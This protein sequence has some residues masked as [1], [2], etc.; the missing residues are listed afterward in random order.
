[1]K[2]L[3]VANR[4][5]VA[6]RIIRT[7]HALGIETVAVY[8]EAD[9]GALHVREATQACAI[10]GLTSADSYLRI[11]KLVSA[12]RS[13]GADAVHPG[14][15]FLSENAEFAQAVE[16]AGITWV[17][18]GADAIRTL[19]SKTRA[20]QLAHA[21]GVPCLPGYEGPDQSDQAFE[22]AGRDLGFPLM[23]KAAAGG[24]GRGMRLVTEAARLL[25]AVQSA[26]SEALSAFGSGELLLECALLR[27][28]H[29]EIQVFADL[30]GN[31][32]H[33]GERDCSVQRRHQ[34]IIEETPSPA[35][36]PELREAMGQCAIELARAAGYV[37]AGTVEFLLDADGAFYLMEMNTRLQVEHP[38]TEMVTGL[39]LVEWQLRIACGERL[40]CRQ[41]ELRF[42]GHAIEVRLCAEDEHFVPHSGRIS[43]FLPPPLGEGRGGG[44]PLRF[45]HAIVAGLDV[46]PHYDSMLGKLIAHAP[47]RAEAISRLTAGLERLQVLGLPTNRR[48]LSA[49]LRH[50]V[51]TAGEATLPFLQ[52]HGESLR[53][54]LEQEEYGAA[55]EAAFCALLPQGAAAA[56]PSPFPRPLRIEHRGTHFDVPVCEADG[57]AA[58]QA[59]VA[60]LGAGR[61]H[62]QVGPVDLFLRDASFDPPASSLAATAAN[63]L[64]V[65][66]N[67]RVIAVHACAGDAVKKGDTLVV[68]ESMKLEHALAAARDGTVGAV[69]VEAGQQ[70]ATA[71]VLVTLAAA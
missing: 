21:R 43:V 46:P 10:G 24:G 27:P 20:K 13:S 60:S 34:K 44:T 67:G 22:A 52:E 49:C 71:Q 48:F 45:D 7:A 3:L 58:G 32:I 14:Y 40:P 57:V 66:F 23:V 8:S 64:R 47:T 54:Q 59:Q 62:V 15:G 16:D 61:W 4:G 33:L 1:M 11:D 19:G 30:H 12:A 51:F 9:R 5:E 70:V 18:P 36:V 35:V 41:S 39:D 42:E 53:H 38:V 25:P 69:H 31:C 6:R 56:L 29:V 55:A 50:P 63:E 26:R 68:V 28:R 65:P 2:R 17:G 37:G